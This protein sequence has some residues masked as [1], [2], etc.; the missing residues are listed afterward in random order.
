MTNSEQ[1]EIN[2]EELLI[3]I[4][5]FILKKKWLLLSFILIGFIF[6]VIIIKKDTLKYKDFYKKNY[7]IY[8]PLVSKEV[9][10]EILKNVQQNTLIQT[11]NVADEFKS[12]NIVYTET[13]IYIT[14]DGIN[15]STG[16]DLD[17]GVSITLE[18]YSKE[19]IKD[20]V[21]IITLCIDANP[22]IKDIKERQ[23]LFLL[24]KKELL[25]HLNKKI[26][27][28]DSYSNVTSKKSVPSNTLNNNEAA[29]I[30]I[31][32][33]EEKQAIERNLALGK[34]SVEFIE[35]DSPIVFVS[36]RPNIIA[37]IMGYCFLAMVIGIIIGSIPNF[38]P[39]LRAILKKKN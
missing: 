16:N 4:C 3:K 18:V 9:L 27:E 8:S 31:R 11:S 1:S 6:G 5:K 24:Q 23:G 22:Y 2:L 17:R 39:T 37:T 21:K 10:I 34:T 14:P 29:L 28:L 32:L 12:I 36:S 7:I 30:S 15:V 25:F 13:P 38:K 33:L 19:K 35:T 26:Q 20:L